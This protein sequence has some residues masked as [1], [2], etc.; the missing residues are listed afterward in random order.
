MLTGWWSNKNSKKK[1]HNI[2][3]DFIMRKFIKSALAAP[4]EPLNSCTH[5]CNTTSTGKYTTAR[6][7]KMLQHIHFIM[8]L[9][10]RNV[11]N[12]NE[13]HSFHSDPNAR[14]LHIKRN[15]FAYSLDSFQRMSLSNSVRF[16]TFKMCFQIQVFYIVFVRVFRHVWVRHVALSMS[17][18]GYHYNF[19][20]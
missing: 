16:Y 1:L 13:Q 15:N 7:K 12:K 10:K 18:I 8:A 6:E 17:E 3:T 5:S 20:L 9:L 2:Q 4:Y 19:N 14:K 11:A